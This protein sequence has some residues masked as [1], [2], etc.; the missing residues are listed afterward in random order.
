[1]PYLEEEAPE[2]IDGNIVENEE[3]PQKIKAN[4]AGLQVKSVKKEIQ[5]TES[6]EETPKSKTEEEP[7]LC[8]IEQQNKIV[9]IYK[10]MKYANEETKKKLLLREFCNKSSIEELT[11]QEAEEFFGKL[12]QGLKKRIITD[13]IYD[14]NSL[15][16]K[17]DTI[18]S[19]YDENSKDEKQIL[20]DILAF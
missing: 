9:K 17:I 16:S 7:D 13:R 4:L 11:S 20:D 1:M 5:K 6:E 10:F 15:S 8:S 14:F 18:S 2:V 3:K 19:F 12:K